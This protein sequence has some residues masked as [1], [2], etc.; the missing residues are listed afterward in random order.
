MKWLLFQMALLCVGVTAVQSPVF[1]QFNVPKYEFGLGLGM[2]VYQGDLTPRRLGSFETQKFSLGLTASRL[3]SP[4]FSA[5]AQLLFGKLKGD[6]ARY[7]NPE[8]RQERNF[9]FRS[10][11]TELSGQLVWNLTAAN[12]T[13][14]GFSPYLFAGA[15]I[16]VIKVRRDWSRMNGA[17]FTPE[18]AEIWAGL[19]AD[20]AHSLPRVIPVVPLGGGIR[21]FFNSQ[22]GLNAEATYRLAT[23]DYLDGFSQSA[24][25]EKKD[26]YMGYSLGLIYRSGKKNT[27]KCPKI[28][29]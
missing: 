21:Y 25:P 19:A 7:E 15:G 3:F 23:T 10:P 18:T 9:L 8:F 14:K 27:L 29:Y 22:W 5:R 17:Y 16:S 12:Y 6:D 11:V 1:C 13:D 4:S 28:H 20:S 26:N 24:N 2:L